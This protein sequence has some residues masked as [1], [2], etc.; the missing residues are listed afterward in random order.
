M[1]ACCLKIEAVAGYD[2]ICWSLYFHGI[3]FTFDQE[4]GGVEHSLLPAPKNEAIIINMTFFW[5]QNTE[6]LPELFSLLRISRDISIYPEISSG[7]LGIH[8]LL[9][10]DHTIALSWKFL[11]GCHTA[12][13]GGRGYQKHCYPCKQAYNLQIRG[14]RALSLALRPVTLRR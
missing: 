3:V 1:F 10:L 7:H 14:Q 9:S 2:L 4:R 6:L 8:S 13:L 12:S 5:L 11:S